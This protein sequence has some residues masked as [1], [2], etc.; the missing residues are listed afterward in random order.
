MTEAELKGNHV[1][2]KVGKMSGLSSGY[3]KESPWYEGSAV[4]YGKK[5][6]ISYL[7]V[8]FV[9]VPFVFEKGNGF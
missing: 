3:V 2:N 5:A 8:S 1:W 7:Y 4:L 6:G 9:Q